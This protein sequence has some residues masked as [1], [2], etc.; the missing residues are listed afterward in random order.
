MSEKIS[1]RRFLRLSGGL[2]GAAT[3]AACA[4][5]APA[6]APAAPAATEAPAAAAATAAPA[7]T[8]APAA[9]AGG[10]ND[11]FPG[12]TVRMLAISGANYDELYKQII[13][14][15]EQKTG[16]KVEYAFKG[17]GFQTDKRLVQDLAAGSVD[18]DVSWDHSS[19]FSEYVKVD[20]LEPLEGY[21]TKDELS[22][23]IPRLIDAT[24][25]KGHLWVMPRLYD[26][27]AMLYQTDLVDK[28]PDTWDEFKEIAL[29]A[30]NK[31]K[32]IY[33]TQFAGK[34]EA[35]SG[36]FYEI[37]IAEGG[38][39]FDDQWKPAFNSAAGVKV[40]QMFQDL[41]KAGAMP[42]GMT[43]FVWED[44]AKN[45]ANGTIGIYNEWYG[46]YSFFQDPKSSKVAGKFD[47][48]RQ[49]MGD[50]KIHSGWAGHHG[51]SIMKAA[52]NKQAGASLIKALT[53]VEG[54]RVEAKLGNLIPRQS[55]WK[56]ML[57]AA[58]KS[59]N[60]LDKKRLDIG[61]ISTQEDFKTP[62]LIA[63]WLPSSNA[64]YPIFQK[65]ILGDL[66]PKDG[67]DQAAKAVEKLM[68]DAGYYKA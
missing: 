18:Y 40:G 67:L 25:T 28:A 41:Y 34:E 32:G 62:P 46:W 42:P 14:G 39:F 51:F 16:A 6:P 47:I 29:K 58:A 59:S 36:R 45:F 13:P 57:D 54:S 11:S 56:E 12:V 63:E 2:L 19:F 26:I 24:T 10:S 49:P 1:R 48:S 17:D 23:F 30:T 31:D 7:P 38:Q 60:P 44:V 8:T 66:T 5:I 53:S 37:L 35:L 61:L 65:V 3:L 68:A 43:N 9:A 21:W 55:V 50:G 33:G 64:F 27:S 22:D 52:K 20:G 15:W 4:P